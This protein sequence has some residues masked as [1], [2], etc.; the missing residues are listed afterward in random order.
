MLIKTRNDGFQHDASS[1]ITPQ[2]AYEGRRALL[3]ECLPT[4]GFAERAAYDVA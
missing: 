4:H 2:R 1:D 3:I